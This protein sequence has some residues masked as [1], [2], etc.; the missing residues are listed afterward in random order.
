[1]NNLNQRQID[2]IKN[3]VIPNENL[4]IDDD[5][6]GIVTPY[7][8]QTNA[9]QS[10]FKGT[11]VKADTV[12][13]FQGQENKVIILSTV[14]NII[15]DFTDNPSRLNVA[16]SRAIEQLIVIVSGNDTKNDS[17]IADLVKY[18]EYNNCEIKESKL[19]SIFDYLY[20]CYAEQREI[21]LKKC[22]KIS[23]YAS[24]NIFF[25]TL[26]E[27]IAENYQNTY[28]IAIR[29]PL[30]KIIRDF[31]LLNS[32][33]LKYASND[34]THIDFLI[35]NKLT[36]APVIAIEVDGASYHKVGSKQFERDQ[37]KNEI[38]EKYELP[39]LRFNTKDYVDK[40]VILDKLKMY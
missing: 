30:N 25:N 27:V 40:K 36:K 38:M 8:N 10:Q 13:K 9:L 28:G 22:D 24:E 32:N 34:W 29:V 4:C 19:F 18:I 21:Y 12:D 35:Y 6:L 15:K 16:I 3:E 1:M 33:Q 7:R 14:D 39:L 26:K 23:K 20:E 2:V 17:N 5:S 37:I 31:S 11:G